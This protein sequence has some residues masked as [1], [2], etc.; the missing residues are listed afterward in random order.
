[1]A[2]R[3]QQHSTTLILVAVFILIVLISCTPPVVDYA[4]PGVGVVFD[5]H[6]QVVDIDAG[7]P[8]EQAGLQKGDILVA[9]EDIPFATEMEK[10]ETLI[11]ESDRKPLRLEVQRNRQVW[12][13][14]ITPGGHNWR[15][16]PI[17]TPISPSL[18][19]DYL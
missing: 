17:P 8:A 6:V 11:W 15:T 13:F 1:M 12:T 18:P 16:S 4:A 19:L 7:S 2:H 9:L 5:E 10:A 3:R 14:I